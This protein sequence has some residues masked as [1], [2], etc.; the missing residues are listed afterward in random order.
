MVPTQFHRMLQLPDDVRAEYDEL[1]EFWR[2]EPHLAKALTD[3]RD[4]RTPR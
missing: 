2:V 1:R 4:A 3:P